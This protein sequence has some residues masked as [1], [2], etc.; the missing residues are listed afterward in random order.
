MNCWVGDLPRQL[1]LVHPPV[2]I[3]WLEDRFR[4][5]TIFC[6]KGHS[7]VSTTTNPYHLVDHQTAYELIGSSQLLQA[8]EVLMQTLQKDESNDET[9][10][11][12]GLIAILQADTETAQTLLQHALSLNPQR[13]LTLKLLAQINLEAGQNKQALKWFKQAERLA[14]DDAEVRGGLGLVLSELGKS[15]Q[16]GVY[17]K[18][19]AQE[20]GAGADVRPE[21]LFNAALF[22]LTQGQWLLAEETLRRLL[23][24]NPLHDR[25]RIELVSVLKKQKKFDEAVVFLRDS[26]CQFPDDESLKIELMEA[27]FEQELPENHDEVRQFGDQD[28]GNTEFVIRAMFVL[29]RLHEREGRLH[30]AETL[31]VSLTKLVPNNAIVRNSAGGFFLKYKHYSQAFNNF[32]AAQGCAGNDKVEQV[33]AMLGIVRCAYG[34]GAPELAQSYFEDRLADDSKADR[35]KHLLMLALSLSRDGFLVPAAKYARMAVED[36][37]RQQEAHELLA[38]ILYDQGTDID[39]AMDFLSLG[40]SRFP[41]SFYLHFM[42]SNLG[43]RVADVQLG[44]K[45]I[46]RALQIEPEN[47]PARA[48]QALL[49]ADNGQVTK[50]LDLYRELLNTS[51]YHVETDK[52]RTNYSLVLS[53]NGEV[54]EGFK[55]H[56]IRHVLN[57]TTDRHPLPV[58]LADDPSLKGKCLLITQEQGIGDEVLYVQFIT[59]LLQEGV[60]SLTF[61]VSQKLLPLFRRSFPQ[62]IFVPRQK[63]QSAAFYQNFDCQMVSGDVMERHFLQHGCFEVPRKAF[64]RAD[65]QRS[66]WWK[67]EL[68]SL[69]TADRPLN[70][71]ICWR[72]SLALGRRQ[73]Y[74]PAIDLWK[75]LMALQH[76]NWINVQYDARP[77]EL[78]DLASQGVILHDYPQTDQYNDLDE[79]AAM[80][81]A[82]DMVVSA[83]VSVPMI[84]SAVGTPSWVFTPRS[85]WTLFGTNRSPMMPY[86]RPFTKGY[87]ESWSQPVKRMISAL[88]KRFG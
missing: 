44:L 7:F 18:Q 9:W 28:W 5:F 46:R 27:L 13:V 43:M 42:M 20:G 32:M 15:K 55:E 11:L 54:A 51:T 71:G 1:P 40:L 65:A 49:C 73:Q 14:P 22:E 17:F 67:R 66:A 23:A 38:K 64:L 79:T 78:D 60:Q 70:I 58:V 77:E 37:P 41:R 62:V 72:S 68:A 26:I 63:V 83:P 16:A 86:T 81:S 69:K 48:N 6:C 24:M 4:L 76:V 85:A 88:E 84:A 19:T 8:H 75:P 59:G 80:L 31:F 3:Y 30:D 35:R 61:E 52:I 10:Q 36:D 87:R 25:A 82:L 50:A 57:K 47:Y 12:L 45:H 34:S 74:W 53:S 2:G 56:R 29:G 33:A 21:F 39:G